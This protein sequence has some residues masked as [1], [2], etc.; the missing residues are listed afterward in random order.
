MNVACATC[1][2]RERWEADGSVGVVTPGG[3]RRAPVPA[4]AEI[5]ALARA[6]RGETGPVV[7]R[8][9]ACG[10]PL[11]SEG[12]GAAAAWEI[13]LP[14]TRLRFGSDGSIHDERGPVT[15]ADAEA[16][17]D[18]LSPREEPLDRPGFGWFQ[19]AVLGLM[20]TPVAVWV[21]SV[22]FVSVFLYRFPVPTVGG[23]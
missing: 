4:R 18:R 8:C 6:A 23:P 10:Q 12:G 17:V 11:V 20:L 2:R 14:G 19:G 22:V 9:S 3:S 16:A 21:F 5:A 13:D 15:L 1:H 7:G